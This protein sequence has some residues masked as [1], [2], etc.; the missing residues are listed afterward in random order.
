MKTET[1]RLVA[2]DTET[3]G[4]NV[5]SPKVQPI[6]VSWCHK[7]GV[8]LFRPDAGVPSFFRSWLADPKVA[9]LFWNAPFDI[10]VLSKIG[11]EVRGQIHDGYIAARL[12]ESDKQKLS[13]KDAAREFLN[14]PYLPEIRLR[15]YVRNNRI[16]VKRTGYGQIPA[17][18]LEPYAVHDARMTFRLWKLYRPKLVEAGMWEVYLRDL[19]AQA[20][21]RAGTRAGLLLD[22]GRATALAEEVERAREAK[23]AALREISGRPDF[24]PN[25]P[26]QVASFVYDGQDVRSGRWTK[27]GKVSTD[28]IALL[29]IG[30]KRAAAILEYRTLAKAK[31]TY[32]KPLL[33]ESVK[34]RIHPS[35]NVVGTRTGRFSSSNP[36]LQNIPRVGEGLLAQMRHC[37]VADPG[38]F[39]VFLDYD[40]VELRLA[41]HFS[42]E[43]AM[44]KAIREGK[45]LH[46]ETAKLVFNI[47]EDHPNWKTYRFLGKTLNLS[48]Q[49]GIG[50][51]KYRDAVFKL[52]SRAGNPLILDLSEASQHISDYKSAHPK[53]V[54]LFSKID[55]EVAATGGVRN[56]YGRFIRVDPSATYTGVNY[57]IQ[58]TSAD[59]MKE[60]MIS[61]QPLLKDY[62]AEF[63]LTVH[64][65]LIFSVPLGSKALV[66]KLRDHMEVYDRFTV[67]LTCSASY[68]R[69]WGTKKDIK[70]SLSA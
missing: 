64:D 39:L 69:S 11:C 51:E 61:C 67:P 7:G 37:F 38:T 25:A 12:I 52:T 5:Y 47:K 19:A 31:S 57:L 8:G 32:L 3:T 55:Q 65:E 54:E 35:L 66:E 53:I 43:P 10:E 44:L 21:A 45:D 60:A 62:G 36:N 49:Y 46:G 9:K 2:V 56:P 6:L 26:A 63:R 48:I 28:E 27:T 17:R 24:N 58:S 22:L 40:Q 1:P 50:P 30:T 42:G 41:A 29:R 33:K 20:V 68:G 23:L 16:D 13:L 4:L 14:D 59:V 18:I 70:R 34:G 15:K